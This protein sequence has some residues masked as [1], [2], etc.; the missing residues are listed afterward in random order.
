MQI[1]R[2]ADH[3]RFPKFHKASLKGIN[4]SIPGDRFNSLQI[5]I[6]TILTMMHSS[7][8]T[9]KINRMITGQTYCIIIWEY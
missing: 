8:R 5:I 2:A 7:V 1:S 4:Y 3:C 6:I 9:V